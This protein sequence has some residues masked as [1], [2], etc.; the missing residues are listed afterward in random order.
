[1]RV[2]RVHVVTDDG[3]LRRPEF[4]DHARS[5]FAAHGAAIALHLRG[6]GTAGAELYRVAAALTGP[7]TAT[8]S[9][10]LVNDRA[11][12]ALAAR[13]GLQLGRRSLPLARARELMGDE[14]LIGYSIHEE[15]EA[16]RAAA[17]GADFLLLGTIWPSPSHPGGGALGLGAVAT[18][19]ATAGVPVLAIG[20]VSPARAAGALGAG[21]H[22]VA[23]LSGVWDEEDPAAATATY[24][25]A[26]E[27]ALP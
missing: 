8:G 14:A 24:V 16:A 15:A 1:V 18:V 9:A 6:H 11:D 2:P 3:V 27:G 17:D 25:E 7:A 12:V 22:G 23:V 19:C 13:C 10:L 5:M 26:V 21:A 20:G 4:I